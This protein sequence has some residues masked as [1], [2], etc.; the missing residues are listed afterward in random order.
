[1]PP[2]AN[3]TAAQKLRGAFYTPDDVAAALVRWVVRRNSDRL[4]DPSC[5][6]GQFLQFHSNAFGVECDSEALTET[7]I[8]LPH[9]RVQSGDFFEWAGKTN[10]RFE[11]AAGNPPFIRYQHFKG[12]QRKRALRLCR[13]WGAEFTA[14]SS[15]WPLFLVGAA[16]LLRPG[17]RMA[18]VVPAEIGHAPYTL[19]LLDYLRFRFSTVSVIAVK[20]KIF[21]TL[22]Q[23][24]WLLYASGAG[25]TT[26][27]I[28]FHA[29]DEFA[30]R[31]TPPTSGTRLSLDELQKFGGRLRPFLLPEEM[32]ELYLQL[33]SS[34][35]VRR[36]GDFA[37][38]GIGYV[39]GD[40]DFFHLSRKKA[41]S[42][43]IEDRYLMP[44]VR[45]GRMLPNNRLTRRQVSSWI[46]DDIE[47][48]LL[49]IRPEESLSKA[50]RSYLGSE[51]GQKAQ[52][53][54]KCRNRTP[55]Y[56]VPDVKVP[57]AFLSYMST[58]CP[59][60]TAN[61]AACACTNSIHSVRFAGGRPPI[62]L[63]TV[64]DN[65][66]M[67]FSAEVEGHSLGGGMLKLEP[68]EAGNLLF[69]SKKLRVTPSESAL[70]RE[71]ILRLRRWRHRG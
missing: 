48:F 41:E 24:V 69:P 14:L 43:G 15:C 13:Q 55:W 6:N 51:Q 66:V 62:N 11:C 50:V 21:P 46:E 20:K 9:V 19:P 36:L 12:E 22:S 3:D 65:I 67:A 23:D 57:H 63:S 37:K 4:L 38:V 25:G 40:N 56:S 18:F 31:S 61:A 10:A 7:A 58:D 45:N 39:T 27:F 2:C 33:K 42:W 32:R 29:W 1:M 64:A 5:G 16:R 28:D 49:R 53:T 34:A 70:V 35:D 60:F 71:G 54:Y 68:R 17:G 52:G 8:R 44:T 59:K 26:R 30:Y 47:C